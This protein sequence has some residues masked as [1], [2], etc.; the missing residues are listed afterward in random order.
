MAIFKRGNVYWY[1]FV[2]KGDHIQ[3]STRQG[4]ARVADQ[5]EAAHK[6][7]LAKGEVGIVERKFAPTLKDFSQRFLDNAAIGRRQAPRESTLAFYAHRLNKILEYEPLATARLDKI[8]PESLERYIKQRIPRVSPACINRDLAT[9]RR[10]LHVAWEL[11]LIDRIPKITLLQGEKERDFVLSVDR[12][13]IYMEF[14]PQPLKDVASIMLA[15]GLRVGEAVSLEWSGI[16]L[17]PVNGAKYGYL[18]VRNGKS[19]NARR[20]VPLTA[21]A[22]NML[23]T[24]KAAAKGPWVFTNEEGTGQ[25]SRSTVSHQHTELRRKLKFPEGFV[26]HGFRHTMLTRLG[27]SGTDVFTIKKIAGHSSVTVS[28]K[29]VHPT[30]ESL[31][32]AFERLDD[33]NARAVK[34]LPEGAKVL[35]VATVSATVTEG[36]ALSSRQPV[37]NHCA[38]VAELADARDSKSRAA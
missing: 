25:L 2:W 34:S 20:N 36:Q 30:P 11:S 13:R 22:R 14:A 28:E 12:E 4:N 23:A 5:I 7:R 37:Q 38:G 17:E 35:Q 31:E 21:G 9:I 26:V 18:H 24:R 16:Y 6:T 29:Y 32:R 19:R 8:T 33:Y 3:E 10:L 27:A 1:H 15:S